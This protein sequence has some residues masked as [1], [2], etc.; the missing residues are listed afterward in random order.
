VWDFGGQEEFHDLHVLYLTRRGVC[1]GFVRVK[2]TLRRRRRCDLR[3]CV[4]VCV[5]SSVC[6]RRAV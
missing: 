2:V 3:I 4:C 5:S 6:V 1:V